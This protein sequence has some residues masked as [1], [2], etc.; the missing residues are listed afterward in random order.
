VDPGRST[1]P[2]RESAGREAGIGGMGSLGQAS[3]GSPETQRRRSGRRRW[4]SG[5][6]ERS[7]QESEREES[8]SGGG[9]LSL[10]SLLSQTRVTGERARMARGMSYH[11]CL[12]E[13]APEK[14]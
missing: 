13:W 5:E 14:S 2:S 8:G 11:C 12:V 6:Q 3:V 9:G 10:S 4:R 1:N 7:S